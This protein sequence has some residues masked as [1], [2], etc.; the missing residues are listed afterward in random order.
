MNRKQI[1]LAAAAGLLVLL[2]GTIVGVSRLRNETPESSK[3]L[4]VAEL[5]YCGVNGPRPCIESFYQDGD[6]YL[7]VNVL[8]PNRNYSEFYL[9]I[10]RAG[11]LNRYLCQKD[12]VVPVQRNCLGKNMPLGEMLEFSLIAVTDERVL[13]NGQFAIIGLL[14]A[15]PSVNATETAVTEVVALEETSPPL[16]LEFPTSSVSP[17]S[18]P[19]E[20]SY[21]NS[22]TSYPGPNYP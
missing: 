17:F 11:E 16:L 14:L 3:R 1:I 2:I 9:T 18:T 12:K 7:L 19:T 6:G 5:G 4:L 15:T 20:P 8:T 13:A 22:G 21:P 10:T